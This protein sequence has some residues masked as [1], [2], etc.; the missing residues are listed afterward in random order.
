M[1][2]AWAT[3]GH[4]L[5]APQA[6]LPC[7]KCGSLERDMTA[8]DAKTIIEE[9]ERVSKYLAQKHYQT[10]EGL[11]RIFRLTVGADVEVKPAEPIKLLEVNN[12]TFPSGV[13][14]LQ[15]GPVSASGIP[16]SSVIVEV[17]PMEF[18]KIE[19][20]E[21]KLPGGWSLGEE[22]PKLPSEDGVL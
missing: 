11:T 10:E 19:N 7:P 18:A 22:I 15:F 12:N 1:A 6:G 17:T 3:C 14:P 4:P 2:I 13:M 5:K 21:L 16:F 8:E 9:K 20:Q